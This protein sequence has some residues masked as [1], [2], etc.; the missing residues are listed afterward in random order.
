M[1]SQL[2]QGR[3]ATIDGA[4]AIIIGDRIVKREALTRSI[5]ALTRR[6]E[7]DLPAARAKLDRLAGGKK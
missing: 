5:E 4:K 1:A 6:A 7:Q 2:S 3:I